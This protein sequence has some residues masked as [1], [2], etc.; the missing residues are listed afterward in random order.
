M[1]LKSRKHNNYI[2]VV[3]LIVV[4][5]NYILNNIGNKLSYHIENIVVKNVDKSVYNYI[6]VTFDSEELG[7][8]QLLDVINLNTNKEGE[9][10]SVDYNLDIAYKYLSDSMNKLYDNITDM[11]MDTL[12]KSGTN[13]VYY[14]PMG[15]IYNNVLVDHLG[16]KIPCKIDFISDIDMGFKTKVKNYGVNN[17]LIEL[18]MVIDVKN[19]IMS[20][21]SYKEF[22]N[23]YEV[24]VASKLVVGKIPIYYGDVLEKT[25]AIVSS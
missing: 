5:T 12:Y 19:H 15:L 8:P 24:I 6:F 9:V 4:F 10:V 1:K 16:Y 17:L 22:G 7:N 18:Y 3:I 23:T 20:P 13:N 25:S 2:L 11:S 21:S 14:L